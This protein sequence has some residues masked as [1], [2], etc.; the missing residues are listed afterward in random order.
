VSADWRVRAVSGS[1][2]GHADWLGLAPRPHAT[3]EWD[4]GAEGA[5]LNRYPAIWT[6]GLG[7]NGWDQAH[8]C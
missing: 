7:L 1:G 6:T 5:R 3:D 2:K 4:P 8:E